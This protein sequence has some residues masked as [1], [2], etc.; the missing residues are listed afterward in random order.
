MLIA[1]LTM[2]FKG[3]VKDLLKKLKINNQEVV[4]KVN[5]KIVP[6]VAELEGDEEIE[7]VRV[8]ADV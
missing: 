4:V 1:K 2:K 7:I 3:K 5:G 6:E 8:V